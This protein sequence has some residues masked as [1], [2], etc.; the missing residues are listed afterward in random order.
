MI[1]LAA[2]FYS[3]CLIHE[4]HYQPESCREFLYIHHLIILHSMKKN[5]VT[6]HFF[7]AL[8]VVLSSSHKF[9]HSLV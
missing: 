1:Y 6:P 9:V 4:L 7:I 3:A 8:N 2:K 5:S